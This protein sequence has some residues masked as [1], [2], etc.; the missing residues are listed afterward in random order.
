VALNQTSFNE[1][2]RA[3]RMYGTMDKNSQLIFTANGHMMGERFSNTGA[4]NLVANF[5]NNKG[6]SVASVAI[7]EGVPGRRGTVTQLSSSAS[8]SFTPAAGEHFYYAKITQDDGKIL[9]SAPIWVTQGG[10]GGGGTPTELIVNGGFEAGTSPWLAS[11]GVIGGTTTATPSRSGTA[12]AKLD[13]YGTTHTDSLYQQVSIPATATSA[14]LSVWLRV[15]SNSNSTTTAYDTLKIQVR[16][17]SNAVLATLAT[18]SNLN[19]GSSYLNKTFDL[20]AYKGKTVRIYFEGIED[21]QVATT[22]LIDD[23]SL[24]VK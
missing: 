20:G 3:R 11:S 13:G 15:L 1:A 17:S 24:I 14:S 4:L 6:R 19:K 9:W 23:V 10:T 18:Y 5:A 12:R 2:L 22:F 16:N 21:T 8:T 7:M